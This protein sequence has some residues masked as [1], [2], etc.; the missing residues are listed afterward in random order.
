MA[1]TVDA[2]RQRMDALTAGLPTKSARIRRLSAAGYERAEIARYLGI[3]Y[4]FVYNVLSAPRPQE[5]ERTNDPAVGPAEP[6]VLPGVARS[7]SSPQWVWT[8]VGKGGSVAVPMAFLKALGV[9]EQD[10]VQLELA[11]DAIRISGRQ[12]ALRE[13]RELVRSRIPGGVKLVDE[14]IAERRA[15]AAMED[16]V[17][18][19]D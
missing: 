13:V 9:G 4:Q 10:P 14:L 3:R 15:E 8:T 17:E 1:Q 18:A 5:S 6:A 7:L 16:S 11:G 2:D 12:A 19:D